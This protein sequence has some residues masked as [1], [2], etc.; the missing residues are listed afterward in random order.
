M[1]MPELRSEPKSNGRRIRPTATSKQNLSF[2]VL[3][4]RRSF[5]RSSATDSDQLRFELFVVVA[6][7]FQTISMFDCMSH[8]GRNNNL[9]LDLWKPIGQRDFLSDR[10]LTPNDDCGSVLTEIA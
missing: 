5:A 3:A 2:L 7:E 9:F 6:H 4:L 8:H 10:K 1:A